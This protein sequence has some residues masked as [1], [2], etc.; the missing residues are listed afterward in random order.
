MTTIVG[1]GHSRRCL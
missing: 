1:V